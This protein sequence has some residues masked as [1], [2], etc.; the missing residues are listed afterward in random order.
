MGGTLPCVG[1][2]QQLGRMGAVLLGKPSTAQPSPAAPF[3]PAHAY[4][5][6]PTPLQ[7]LQQGSSEHLENVINAPYL[8]HKLFF[9][10]K[11]M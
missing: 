1:H 11:E 5:L 3:S 9:T 8:V 6:P 4:L 10:A 2:V 7:E